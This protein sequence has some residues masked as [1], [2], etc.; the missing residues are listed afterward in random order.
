MISYSILFFFIIFL[1]L[2][3]LLKINKNNFYLFSKNFSPKNN[4]KIIL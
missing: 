4:D 2:L 1:I 3:Y